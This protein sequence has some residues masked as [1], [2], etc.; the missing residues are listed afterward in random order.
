[1]FHRIAM[2][3]GLRCRRRCRH[4]ADQQAAQELAQNNQAQD[5]GL[6]SASHHVRLPW[7]PGVARLEGTRRIFGRRRYRPVRRGWDGQLPHLRSPL[8][9][10]ETLQ[11]CI[12]ACLECATACEHCASAC[13]QE[14][15]PKPMARCIQL[16]L[17]C[18]QLCHT[19]ASL[20]G[21]GSGFAAEI[22]TL[23]ATICDAC[24]NE[25]RRHAVEHCQRCADACE[26]CA[27]ECRRMGA[28]AAPST[29]S[30]TAHGSH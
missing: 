21:R 8:M 10:H 24:A 20:M 19:A 12:E 6:E 29:A 22:C 16:D 25:C 28:A 11:R 4:E 14:N 2:M 30:T 18:A 3:L 13:L 9:P 27:V 1:M 26:R 15:D 7:H 23:C 17:D 5:S